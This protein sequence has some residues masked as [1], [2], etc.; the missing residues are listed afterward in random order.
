VPGPRV[1]VPAEGTRSYGTGL[2]RA[3]AAAG[4]PGIECERPSRR[5][6]RG[7][8]QARSGRCAPGGAGRAAAGRRPACGAARRR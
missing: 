8:G 2:A 3:L 4:L 1:A 7:K 6:R 5:R